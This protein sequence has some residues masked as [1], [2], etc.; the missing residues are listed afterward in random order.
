MTLSV[1]SVYTLPASPPSFSL[2]HRCSKPPARS[3]ILRKNGGMENQKRA[4]DSREAEA[5]TWLKSH[6]LRH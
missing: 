3:C 4:G 2:I 5:T 6:G 1:Y